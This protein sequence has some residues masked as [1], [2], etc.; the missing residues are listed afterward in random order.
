M[1]KMA[2]I[3]ALVLWA[4]QAGAATYYIDPSCGSSG[5]GSTTSCGA[6]GPFTSWSKVTWAAGNSYC[7]KGGTTAYEQVTVGA[8]GTPKRPI[9]ITSYGTGRARLNGGIVIPPGAW[10]K[11]DP[12]AGVYSTRHFG[13]NLLEDGIFLKYA[14]SSHCTDGNFYQVR[15]S[16]QDYYRPSRGVPANHVVERMRRAGI[17]LGT[18]SYVEIANFSFEKFR[19]GI[20]GNAVRSGTTNSHITVTGNKFSNLEFGVWINFNDAVSHAIT[21]RDNEFDHLFTSISLQNQG[22]CQSNGDHDRAAI[23]GNVISHCSE[24]RGAEGAYGWEE[25]DTAGWDMEGIGLQDLINSKVD[26]NNI[27]GICRGIV[28]YTCARGESYNNRFSF[29]RI[30]TDRTPLV[31]QPKFTD[32]PAKSFYNNRASF[33][34]LIG[35]KKGGSSSGLYLTN[36]PV[37]SAP[38]EDKKCNCIFNNT[39]IPAINGIYSDTTSDYYRIMNNIIFGAVNYQIVQIGPSAPAHIIYNHNLYLGKSWTKFY[40]NNGAA[41]DFARWQ[42]L[43]ENYDA[44]SPTPANPL[45]SDAKG[46]VYTLSS[47]SPARQPGAQLDPDADCSC[48]AALQGTGDIGAFPLPLPQKPSKP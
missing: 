44:K 16:S 9:V 14:S 12:V 7:Q 41:F 2:L 6:H 48:R 5:D 38:D 23:S 24:V 17:Q 18:N 35:G 15:A 4:A 39:I 29:N 30:V 31:F 19:Y 43:G 22:N 27:S 33:N 36:V 20:T 32:P 28:M 37:P 1:R 45:F 8:S 11:N 21:V 40:T 26:H 34:L 25:V 46:E 47:A 3:T 42:A 10:K 13:Y